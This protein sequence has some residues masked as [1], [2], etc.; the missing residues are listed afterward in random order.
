MQKTQ[1]TAI[2]NSATTAS[3]ELVAASS[4]YGLPIAKMSFV[5]LEPDIGG[6]ER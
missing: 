2:K 1:T 5:S 6:K 4:L 3:A